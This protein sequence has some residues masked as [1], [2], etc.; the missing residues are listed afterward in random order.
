LAGPHDVPHDR[1][2]APAGERL[3]SDGREDE[4]Q[5]AGAGDERGRQSLQAPH[6]CVT[7]SDSAR[8]HGS[9]EAAADEVAVKSA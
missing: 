8:V 7:S 6:R 3:R 1:A 9:S 5:S 2:G 4:C